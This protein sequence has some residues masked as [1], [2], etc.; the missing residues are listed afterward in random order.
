[1][2]TPFSASAFAKA[3]TPVLSE[4]LINARC[5]GAILASLMGIPFC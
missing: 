1:M 3:T 2:V 4:T 5:I